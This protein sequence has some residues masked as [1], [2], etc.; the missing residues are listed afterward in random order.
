MIAQA[1]L[2]VLALATQVDVLDGAD[3]VVRGM[4]V[5]RVTQSV[6]SEPCEPVY[7]GYP[8]GPKTSEFVPKGARRETI[9]AELPADFKGLVP[10]G[11]D[12]FG[13]EVQPDAVLGSQ[14]GSADN[15]RF[16]AVYDQE[17]DRL[18]IFQ[19]PRVRITSIKGGFAVECEGSTRAIVKRDYVSKHLGYFLWDK[20]KPLWRKPVAG[21]CSWMAHL[22]DVD[23][24]A[25]RD[26]ASLFSA[27][28]REYGYDVIQMDDGFQRVSQS[29][30]PPLKPGEVF[31]EQ[32]TKPNA[33]FPSG[34]EALAHDISAK[35]MTPGIWVGLYMPLG[36][37]NADGYVMDKDGKPVRGPWV[38][39][40]VNGLMPKALDEAY[41]KTIRDLK[42]MGWR[43][44]KI[45]T[46]RHVIYDNY[47]L[48]PD[49]W[50]ARGESPEKAF[51]KIM[52]SIKG[53]AGKDIYVLACWG[54][55]PELA[56]LPDGCRIGEDVGPNFA[57]MRR[58]A[59]YIAQFQYLNNVVWLNDPDYMCLRLPAEQ[60][61]AW[62]TL[63]SLAGGHIMDSDPI[64]TLDSRRVELLRRVGPPMPLRPTVV[65]PL[66][67]DPAF[68]TL[69]AE[70]GGERWTVAARFAWKP[71]PERE[72]PLVE[73]GLETDKPYLAFDFWRSKFL[74]EVSGSLLFRELAEGTCQAVSFRPSLARPQ[75]L[76]TDRHLG[77]GVCEYEGVRWS[78]NTLSGTMKRGNGQAW[79]LYLHVPKG[80]KLGTAEVSGGVVS[81][82]GEV[83]KITFPEGST[84]V[85]WSVG[86]VRI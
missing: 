43:Y 45:D 31:A 3:V 10:T 38:N 73:L 44:F 61:E 33:K 49:Y 59:K 84:D 79:S 28:L 29:G 42:A 82:T 34:L 13:C 24:K 22:Q 11:K 76:G 36:I 32:W 75:V 35:G 6:S 47:R 19:A 15:T 64:S 52:A 5:G 46:L 83:V 37:K 53:I 9:T 48:A 7:L 2:G 12:A 8:H 17:H 78:R 57:S 71:E 30:E 26:A 67:P 1:I 18:T 86:F 14:V 70:K 68:V 74:G 23:E 50:K 62:V 20:R 77:Q 66:K 80:W 72:V 39:Y 60:A 25:M 16:N 63:T 56:G 54:T 81:I 58:S 41:L 85:V 65:A 51:R 40:A 4:G 27:N 21:W 69:S 55:L